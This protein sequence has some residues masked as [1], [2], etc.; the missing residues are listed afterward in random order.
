TVQPSPR[1]D[2][3]MV[4]MPGI[5][6]FILFGGNDYSGPNFAF[7][8]LADTWSYAWGAN[9]WTNLTR[10]NGPS[11]RDYAI[12]AADPI[13]GR[14]LMTS[15]FGDGTPLN[16]LWSFN[17]TD[18]SWIPLNA[19]GAPPSR[20]AGVG[21]F[22]SLANLLVVFGGATSTGLLGDTW[23]YNPHAVSPDATPLWLPIAIAAII[24]A[25]EGIAVAVFLRRN[26]RR[27]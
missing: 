21:G 9:A 3:R 17:L 10:A 16:D 27:P 8:H 6:R 20:F 25:A 24:L 15:G 7:H 2:G 22:D 5:D 23:Y 14:V 1:A 18:E 11:A 26:A 13:S 4:Y 12:M 19:G